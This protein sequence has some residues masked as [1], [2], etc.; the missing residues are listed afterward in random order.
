M[1]Y[2]DY[3]GP[4]GYDSVVFRGDPSIVDGKASRFIAFWVKDGRVLAG[5]NVNIWD[6]VDDIRA[7]AR[8][9]YAGKA[10]DLARL[11]APSVAADL[12]T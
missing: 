1:E 5:L 7:L 4:E 6:V 2:V 12:L 11:A 8:A 10:V 9:G 3:V